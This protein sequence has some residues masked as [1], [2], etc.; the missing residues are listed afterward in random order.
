MVGV[1]TIPTIEDVVAVGDEVAM[2]EV[3]ADKTNIRGFLF[4]QWTCFTLEWLVATTIFLRHF[5]AYTSIPTTLQKTP[6]MG[7]SICPHPMLPQATPSWS[8]AHHQAYAG[9]IG[10]CP[11]LS[12]HIYSVGHTPAYIEQALHTISLNPPNNNW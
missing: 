9:I 6:S 7:C 12:Y 10:S 2:D 8:S 1:I 11:P 3:V 4:K 5:L